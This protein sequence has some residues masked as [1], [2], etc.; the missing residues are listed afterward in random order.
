MSVLLGRSEKVKPH[1]TVKKRVMEEAFF[2]KGEFQ[3]TPFGIFRPKMG[4]L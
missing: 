3:K 1:G 2:E 4:V